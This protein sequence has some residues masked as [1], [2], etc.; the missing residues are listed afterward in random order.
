MR[1]SPRR[2]RRAPCTR[3]HG[4]VASTSPVQC[5]GRRSQRAGFVGSRQ[6]I[7][8]RPFPPNGGGTVRA[9]TVRAGHTVIGGG[10]T[11]RAPTRRYWRA[12]RISSRTRAASACPCIC[13]I[14]AP[15]R[16]PAAWTFPPRILSA[17]PGL[18]AMASSTARESVSSSETTS[19]PRALTISAG[20]PSPRARPR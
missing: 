9:T 17:T 7:I 10:V 13:F 3:A 4:S 2:A 18:A 5:S 14:T 20:S 12:L 16:A 15:M 19:S 11:G 6:P 1:W 8:V